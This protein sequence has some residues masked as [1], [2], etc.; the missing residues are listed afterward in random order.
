VY[1][2]LDKLMVQLL[3]EI[4]PTSVPYV[5]DDGELVVKLDKALYGCLQAS[6]LWYNRLCGVLVACGFEKNAVDPCVFSKGR[7]KDRCTMCVHVDD[8][9]IVDATTYLTEELVAHL[10]NEFDDVK[11]NSGSS[12]S[13]LGMSFDFSVNGSVKV[14]MSHYISTLLTEYNVTNVAVT[15]AEEWLFDVRE[16]E[17]LSDAERES[18]HSAVAKLLFLSKRYCTK[19]SGNVRSPEMSG[20]FLKCD[21]KIILLKARLHQL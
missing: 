11:L 8:L 1:L 12:H 20:N 9:L 5:N 17:L 4:D 19:P 3:E 15:P 2:R 14:S 13:Y 10:K 7:G 21:L 6:L 16:A 18:F